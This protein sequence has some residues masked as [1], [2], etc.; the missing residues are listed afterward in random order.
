MKLKTLTV[1][2]SSLISFSAVSA[3]EYTYPNGM[4]IKLNAENKN[5]HLSTVNDR[6]ILNIEAPDA[7]SISHNLFDEFNVGK[8]GLI[9]NNNKRA[10]IIINEVVSGSASQL[11]G[12]MH[13]KGKTAG[14]II[15]N[16]NGISCAGCSTSNA[17]AL[18][19]V[20]G[21]ITTDSLKKYPESYTMTDSA[22]RITDTKNS[23]NTNKLALFSRNISIDNSHI[24]AEN[25][26]IRAN[27][28]ENSSPATV[29]ISKNSTLAGKQADIFTA[30]GYFE[31]NGALRSLMTDLVL[32]SAQGVNNGDISGYKFTPAAI[33]SEFRNEGNIHS[34]VFRLYAHGDDTQRLYNP[35]TGKFDFRSDYSFINNGNIAGQ[36]FNIES[37]YRNIQ[38][39]KAVLANSGYKLDLVGAENTGKYD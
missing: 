33:D 28:N 9:I 31:N 22:I 36:I 4:E 18:S 2:I 1:V 35:D 10:D 15:A 11:N 29:K 17:A 12:K 34:A 7:E 26:T 8:R 13:I 23:I 30:N 21:K 24:T 32:H 3:T 27:G 5:A 6:P 25:L 19:L 20:T 38:I 16:P 14:L 39:N 37:L